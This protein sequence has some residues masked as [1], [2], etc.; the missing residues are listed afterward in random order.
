MKKCLVLTLSVVLGL[1]TVFVW[2]QG[3]EQEADSCLA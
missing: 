3:G 1:T 2:A